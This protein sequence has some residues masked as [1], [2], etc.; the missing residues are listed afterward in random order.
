MPPL[1]HQVDVAALHAMQ[2][3]LP[4]L[5]SRLKSPAAEYTRIANPCRLEL[6]DNSVRDASSVER[7]LGT[8][9]HQTRNLL[10]LGSPLPL[11]TFS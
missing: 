2:P 10:N 1:R 11:C 4:R 9:H 6:T 5:P 8:T 7:P 3:Q